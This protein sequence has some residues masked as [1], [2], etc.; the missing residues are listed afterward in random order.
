MELKFH[1]LEIFGVFSPIACYAKLN[2]NFVLLAALLFLSSCSNAA[3]HTD[4]ISRLWISRYQV[5]AICVCGV[6]ITFI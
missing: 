5:N 3:K 1:C 2:E 4:E 6:Q